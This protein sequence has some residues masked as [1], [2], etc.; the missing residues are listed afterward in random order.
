MK[1]FLQDFTIFI[2][3][4]LCATQKNKSIF[5]KS[6][7]VWILQALTTRKPLKK[8]SKFDLMYCFFIL[9]HFAFAFSNF[10]LITIL[11]L[12][13]RWKTFE[14]SLTISLWTMPI[15]QTVFLQ[16]FQNPYEKFS[17]YLCQFLLLYLFLYL[18]FLILSFLSCLSYLVFL[19]LSFLSCLSYLVFHKKPFI[20]LL[21]FWKVFS[22]FW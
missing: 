9:S 16:I 2:V 11:F 18:A 8:T 13:E 10:K 4:L 12:N 20:N 6:I 5:T 17:I 3:F 14:N 22:Q 21:P 7:S 15:L 19:I 1:S